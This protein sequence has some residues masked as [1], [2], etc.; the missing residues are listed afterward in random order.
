[1]EETNKPLTL[2]QQMELNKKRE[3]ERKAKQLEE[4]Q[5]RA[6]RVKEGTDFNRRW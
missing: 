3:A 1:M 5:R 6:N 4:A 2:E